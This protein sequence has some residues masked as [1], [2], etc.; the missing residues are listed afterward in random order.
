MKLDL[1]VVGEKYTAEPYPYTWKDCI[2]YAVGVGAGA[3]D[4]QYTMETHEQFCALPSYAVCPTTAIVFDVLGKVQADFATLVHGEQVIKFHKPLS[5]D[6]TLSS[7]AWIPTAYDKGKAALVPVQTET[8]D[9]SG[10]LVYETTWNIF[11]RGQGGWGGERGEKVAPL[12]PKAGAE[13]AFEV[14]LATSPSQAALYRLSGDFNPLHINPMVAKMAGFERPILHGLCTFGF[15]VRALVDQ[16]CG[17]DPSK[18]AELRVRFSREVYP[19]D[20]VRVRA[21]ESAEENTWLFD[22]QVGDR[23][24]LSNGVF[25]LR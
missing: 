13:P 12:M 25:T 23:T 24:V 15:A 19:G 20:V 6:G 11:C 9:E 21:I 10:D 2:L 1:S 17:G 8:R 22:A 4:L 16:L 14:E 18:V 3:D 7:V 5:T